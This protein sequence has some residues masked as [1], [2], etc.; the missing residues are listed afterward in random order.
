MRIINEILGVKG[1]SMNIHD[2]I[3]SIKWLFHP[4][5]FR[6][7]PHTNFPLL[8]MSSRLAQIDTCNPQ[9]TMLFTLFKLSDFKMPQLRHS[10]DERKYKNGDLILRLQLQL[11]LIQIKKEA[12]RTSWSHYSLEFLLVHSILPTVIKH[13]PVDA[14]KHPLIVAFAFSTVKKEKNCFWFQYEK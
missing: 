3:G 12:F 5:I 4:A 10:V 8:S 13:M 9:I 6:P 14:V 2:F 1:L 11:K 7:S